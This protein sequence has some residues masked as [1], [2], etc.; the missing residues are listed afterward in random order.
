MARLVSPPTFVRLATRA[1]ISANPAASQHAPIQSA[2]TRTSLSVARASPVRKAASRTLNASPR[3]LQQT[4]AAQRGVAKALESVKKSAEYWA[5]QDATVVKKVATNGVQRKKG[6]QTRIPGPIRPVTDKLN[7][8]RNARQYKGPIYRTVA[9]AIG[10]VDTLV[11]GSSVEVKQEVAVKVQELATMN[12]GSDDVILIDNNADLLQDVSFD[13]SVSPDAQSS[14]MSQWARRFSLGKLVV[15]NIPCAPCPAYVGDG[16]TR[17]RTRPRHVPRF[18]KVISVRKA[19]PA[20]SKIP[21][22][23]KANTK[24]EGKSLLLLHVRCHY[25]Q[26]PSCCIS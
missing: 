1:S 2:D 19:A 10:K 3:A 15:Q 12:D 9:R 24:R 11:D 14:E 13:E 18:P 5:L 25:L 7:T 4:L 20:S 23:A 21:R 22:V 17:P 26:F 6:W 16:L 8:L